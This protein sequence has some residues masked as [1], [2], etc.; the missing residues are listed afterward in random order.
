M[1]VTITKARVDRRD[2]TDRFS[3]LLAAYEVLN[4]YTVPKQLPERVGGDR[5]ATTAPTEA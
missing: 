4:Q 3:G 1:C 2:V 5:I